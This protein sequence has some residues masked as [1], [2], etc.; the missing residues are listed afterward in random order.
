MASLFYG[1]SVSTAT[2]LV[3]FEEQDIVSGNGY[4]MRTRIHFNRPAT[5]VNNANPA[6]MGG[7]QDTGPVADGTI[8]GVITG[9]NDAVN[10]GR[11]ALQ[12]IFM[13]SARSDARSYGRVGFV[14]DS[15]PERNL[16][17]SAVRGA[18]LQ[19]L[20]L[21]HEHNGPYITR[22]TLQFGVYGSPGSP[23]DYSWTGAS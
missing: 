9:G 3:E 8:V 10:A 1:D 14:L 13:R 15:Y 6:S 20:E 17:P 19:D 23:P 2:Q 4:V 5:R 16:N 21:D 22:F 12:T 18:M 11:R 7:F